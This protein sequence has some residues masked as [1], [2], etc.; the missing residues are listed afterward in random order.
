[1]TENYTLKKGKELK[2]KKSTISTILN[3]SK[4]YKVLKTKDYCIG[5]N[6]N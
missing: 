4:S 2:P 3:Y 5:I 1:M 6:V